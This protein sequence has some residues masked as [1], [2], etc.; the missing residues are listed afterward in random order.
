MFPSNPKLNALEFGSD[1][2]L[3]EFN[4]AIRDPPTPFD[5]NTT[6][7]DKLLSLK[8]AELIEE[9]KKGKL[10]NI[11]EK[12]KE[13]MVFLLD[14][15]KA[16]LMA[17][18]NKKCQRVNKSTNGY[19][20][21]GPN[22]FFRFL[23][24]FVLPPKFSIRSKL[25][26][27]SA[28]GENG[29]CWKSYG[30]VVD[31]ESGNYGSS[32]WDANTSM[33]CYI[34]DVV[35][36]SPG[37][38][39]PR[40]FDKSMQCEHL[41]PFT[42]GQI[43]W[44][45]LLNS[46]KQGGDW[47]D[48][49][50]K[51][52]KREYAPVCRK[53]NCSGFKLSL[54]ILKFN[55]DWLDN[56][57]S[58]MPIVELDDDSL[59]K[60]SGKDYPPQDPHAE[61]AGKAD[62]RYKRLGFIFDPL[63]KVIN[64]KLQK[65][66]PDP[67]DAHRKVLIYLINRYM[68]YYDNTVIGKLTSA[69]ITGED[70][71][72]KNKERLKTNKRF[73]KVARA[74]SSFFN[75]I[76]NV[77]Q[78]AQQSAM[79]ARKRVAAAK[80]DLFK[81]TRRTLP[82]AAAAEASA[83]AASKNAQT[84]ED[85]AKKKAE[86]INRKI[87]DI[88]DFMGSALPSSSSSSSSSSSFYDGTPIDSF[89]QQF[90]DNPNLDYA[91]MYDFT[92][93]EDELRTKLEE[94]G[95]DFSELQGVVTAGGGNGDSKDKGQA[96]GNPKLS[97]EI[98]FFL[99]ALNNISVMID[100]GLSSDKFYEESIKMLYMLNEIMETINTR[101]LKGI[102]AEA[103]A[104]VAASGG[105]AKSCNN[106][107]CSSGCDDEETITE[108]VTKLQTGLDGSSLLEADEQLPENVSAI[109]Y[110]IQKLT[111]N[112]RKLKQTD[113]RNYMV[114]KWSQEQKSSEFQEIYSDRNFRG[115]DKCSS[116]VTDECRALSGVKGGRKKLKTVHLYGWDGNYC[117]PCFNKAFN[118]VGKILQK[119]TKFAANKA[120]AE[121]LS[122]ALEPLYVSKPHPP[123]A[124]QAEAQSDTAAA[125][126]AAAPAASATASAEAK[127]DTAAT[128]AEEEA[129][130][131]PAEADTDTLM[132][133]AP[134]PQMISDIMHPSQ[135]IDMLLWHSPFQNLP[136]GLEAFNGKPRL[137]PRKGAQKR[138]SDSVLLAPPHEA[139]RGKRPRAASLQGGKKKTR[140]KRKKKKKKTRR[141]R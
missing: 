2:S 132:T 94:I 1:F 87:K 79:S 135:G 40:G 11:G 72:K 137:S 66:A 71:A 42:E 63:V 32:K 54:G 56:P 93:K 53:C 83:A 48:A 141:K 91:K 99:Y 78:S 80:A 106:T 14:D 131:A 46:S 12:M 35:L 69:F 81:A 122:V 49:F 16:A 113:I 18:D 67:A 23:F 64:E 128:A 119:N 68:S 85:A 112:N 24:D 134:L 86:E 30:T 65:I 95:V 90:K 10:K 29:Q 34:C 110:D 98:G 101:N 4:A 17:L 7:I 59:K 108:Y 50:K 124:P 70:L 133:D 19:Y 97:P 8:G 74:V 62:E 47:T 126:P 138:R 96:G 37:D 33:Q 123:V 73:E 9:K 84:Q 120:R 61:K 121:L 107:S 39:S 6:I 15:P 125:V 77:V 127:S 111:N 5:P 114:G 13:R 104:Q 52:A 36:T 136:P 105:E 38:I 3:P 28:A 109:I 89:V 20:P 22:D 117:V 57:S 26:V 75:R 100:N 55:K 41:F 44:C 129:P 31:A 140:R 88:A 60:I 45:L 102:N 103:E 25:E 139:L 27:P 115:L 118:S 51:M 92:G 43:F 82:R 58:E 21:G 116:M 76:A 130:A